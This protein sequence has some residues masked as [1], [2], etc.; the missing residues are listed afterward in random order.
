MT[1]TV[2]EAGKQG[3]LAALKNQGHDFF[4]EIGRRGQ[5]VMHRKYPNMARKWGKLGGR[6]RKLNLKE[7][8]GQEK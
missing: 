5:R 3:G 8:A 4:A 6:P 7:S 1:M 2:D